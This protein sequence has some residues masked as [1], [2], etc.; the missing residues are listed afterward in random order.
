MKAKFYYTFLIIL[1]IG[2]KIFAQ[3]T[4][5]YENF[6]KGKALYD[7]RLY[8]SAK[9][10]LK[11]ALNQS[12]KDEFYD[13]DRIIEIEN[14][15]LRCDINLE[16]NNATKQLERWLI[17]YK[18][19]LLAQRLISE[20]ARDIVY[21][22]EPK[23]VID[24]LSKQTNLSEPQTF[25]L[26]Y[27]YYLINDLNKAEE[28]FLS[29]SKSIDPDISKPALY[30]LGLINFANKEYQKLI[31]N[32]TELEKK[33]LNINPKVVY[34]EQNTLINKKY[35]NIWLRALY[36]LN[37]KPPYQNI[38]ELA[39]RKNVFIDKS[40]N[41]FD[42]DMQKLLA[43]L[44]FN[45]GKYSQAEIIYKNLDLDPQVDS[46]DKFYH[47]LAQIELAGN[48]KNKLVLI[49][50]ALVDLTDLNSV[51]FRKNIFLTLAK[52]YIKLQEYDLAEKNLDKLLEITSDSLVNQEAYLAKINLKTKINNINLAYRDVEKYMK[53]YPK[54]LGEKRF[55]DTFYELLS[56]ENSL[57][58]SIKNIESF[59]IDNSVLKGVYQK[60][61]RAHLLTEINAGKKDLKALKEIFELANKYTVDKSDEIDNH[62]DYLK[63]ILKE[64]IYF[65]DLFKSANKKL[66]DLDD[67]FEKENKQI[68][69]SNTLE[70]NQD[71]L[72]VR[73]ER[74]FNY[75][76]RNRLYSEGIQLII[77]YFDSKNDDLIKNRPNRFNDLAGILF[78]FFQ[79]SNNKDFDQQLRIVQMIFNSDLSTENTR[80]IASICFEDM[81]KSNK[82]YW[83]DFQEILKNP[84][85]TSK[86]VDTYNY[87]GIQ[88]QDEILNKNDCNQLQLIYSLINS[89]LANYSIYKDNVHSLLKEIE[90]NDVC[91]NSLE[92]K[93]K[94]ITKE[95]N[96]FSQS[97]DIEKLLALY[98]KR[99]ELYEKLGNPDFKNNG[100]KGVA[101]PQYNNIKQDVWYVF[102]NTKREIV[103]DSTASKLIKL[104]RDNGDEL[105]LITQFSKYLTKDQVW[106][107]YKNLRKK[108]S[109]NEHLEA[110]KHLSSTYPELSP[111]FNT[112][113]ELGEIYLEMKD[114]TNA[115]KQYANIISNWK[116]FEKDSTLLRRVIYLLPKIAIR[117]NKYQDL[118]KIHQSIPTQYLPKE[119]RNSSYTNYFIFQARNLSSMDAEKYFL[120]LY[121]EQVS[122]DNQ[123]PQQKKIT[124]DRYVQ[125]IKLYENR[126]PKEN[127]QKLK[128]ILKKT[129]AHYRS[130]TTSTKDIKDFQYYLWKYTDLNAS[131]NDIDDFW[132]A[133]SEIREKRMNTNDSLR[134]IRKLEEYRDL[135]CKLK[136]WENV[137]QLDLELIN[138]GKKI[139]D[140]IKTKTE[141]EAGNNALIDY[142]KTLY[143][144]NKYLELKNFLNDFLFNKETNNSY[145]ETQKVKVYPEAYLFLGLALEKLN[146]CN[147]AK[148]LYGNGLNFELVKK[149]SNI[150]DIIY[151]RYKQLKCNP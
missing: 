75:K 52:V 119:F 85:L 145:Y 103:K 91:Q 116:V 133:I 147:D 28:Y 67:T 134:Y 93:I 89:Y 150:F 19:N 104:A 58:Y 139:P 29:I 49:T 110:L 107:E 123:T 69:A 73:K 50:S 3:G 97:D 149:D 37:N 141:I 96:T 9:T 72:K 16:P 13:E 126:Q 42:R 76:E 53:S 106:K 23:L 36:E 84:R 79:K 94:E 64:S 101:N 140:L 47:I 71:Y 12:K 127:E 34:P 14:Y 60:Y 62:I 55:L 144:Q 63:V 111:Q 77:K 22:G 82:K 6:Q 57:T 88:I 59:S 130:N 31:N 33:P 65:D 81:I 11:L 143:Q 41:I 135:R 80:M 66:Q 87:L 39:E 124:I 122:M 15:I 54:N 18:N 113:Y 7:K 48:E 8:L 128:N 24:L 92:R 136:D 146:L 121:A 98:S 45:S 108:G 4:E 95:I 5:G 56:K 17:K 99:A 83:D 32:Y 142:I 51:N 125:L 120:E 26:A 115:F 109:L 20:I 35:N 61:A 86:E 44:Y 90:Q 102:S 2:F 137:T 148:A 70:K 1:F 129:L 30:Y 25:Y 10:T 38:T 118:S 151:D 46:T 138:L 21:A 27:A 68:N 40:Q 105:F 131:S 114:S 112:N 78:D 132:K 117:K 43:R 100:S 74:E